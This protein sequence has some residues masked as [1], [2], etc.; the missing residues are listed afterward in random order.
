M[1]R[2]IVIGAGGFAREVKWLLGSTAHLFIGFVVTELAFLEPSYILGDLEWLKKNRT[3]WDSLV[4]G[5]GNPITRKKLFEE[6]NSLIPSAH[7]ETLI[8]PSAIIDHGTVKIGPG[9]IITANNIITTNVTIGSNVALNLMCTVGHDSVI[10]DHSVIN[11]T[12]NISG[13]VTIGTACL[14]GTGAQILQNKAVGDYSAVG[15]GAVVTKSF[16]ERSLLVGVPA[17]EK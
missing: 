3:K 16:K 12:V 5:I 13:G 15:A 11:P 7:W 4:I 1:S 10:G 8:H 6:I 17:T 2:V 9:S 14:V